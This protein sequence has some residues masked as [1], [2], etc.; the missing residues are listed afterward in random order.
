MTTPSCSVNCL[1]RVL[2]TFGIHQNS[3]MW[4]IQISK[5]ISTCK[6]RDIYCWPKLV[7]HMFS[8]TYCHRFNFFVWIVYGLKEAKEEYVP[9]IILCLL[10]LP[11][12]TLLIQPLLHRLSTI[13][14]IFI[15]IFLTTLILFVY[16]CNFVLWK[17]VLLDLGLIENPV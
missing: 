3:K 12:E 14:I 1:L 5:I 11:C 7:Q 6:T 16:V 15:H 9:E 2:V 4:Q 17:C 13:I 10:C 8:L